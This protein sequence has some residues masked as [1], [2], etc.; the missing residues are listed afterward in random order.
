M[1]NESY[2]YY[3]RDVLGVAGFPS[4]SPVPQKEPFVVCV[5][6]MSE[7]ERTLVHKI[8]GSIQLSVSNF[9]VVENLN[10]EAVLAL[11]ASHVLSFVVDEGFKAPEVIDLGMTKWWRFCSASMMLSENEALNIERKKQVWTMLQS[12]KSQL[13]S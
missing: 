3:L 11:N 9:N 1:F 2:D 6:D 12:L 4:Q 13:Q 10:V 8:L 7:G 5:P